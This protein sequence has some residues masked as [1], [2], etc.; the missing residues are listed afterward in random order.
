M[1]IPADDTGT[2]PTINTIV[3]DE[4]WIVDN[5]FTEK[6]CK[7]LIASSEKVGYEE[8]LVTVGDDIGRLAS[9]C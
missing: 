2:N 8:A 4:I 1:K 6:Q 7:A 3:K 9:V 5:F